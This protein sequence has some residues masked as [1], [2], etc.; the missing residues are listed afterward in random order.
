V[1]IFV[2]VR[3][4]MV[5]TMMRCPPQHAFL[6]AGLRKKRHQKLESA[7]ELVRAVTEITVIAGSRAESAKK[8]GH[9]EKGGVFPTERN[10]ENQKTGS[11]KKCKR[12]DSPK[13]VATQH[14]ENWNADDHIAGDYCQ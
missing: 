9:T 3:V 5:I 8:I 11:V 13:L 2:I 6:R 1:D 14:T 12:N 4:T 10:K 7:A